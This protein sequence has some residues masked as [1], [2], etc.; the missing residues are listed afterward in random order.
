MR[1]NPLSSFTCSNEIGASASSS[2]MAAYTNVPKGFHPFLIYYTAIEAATEYKITANAS[3][4][5]PSI[6]TPMSCQAHLISPA[7]VHQL[8][9]YPWGV[10]VETGPLKDLQDCSIDTW[11]SKRIIISN[12]N[13]FQGVGIHA[14]AH[15]RTH[16]TTST[17][18]NSLQV[19]ALTWKF[20]HEVDVHRMRQRCCCHDEPHVLRRPCPKSDHLT[21]ANRQNTFI[22]ELR[23]LEQWR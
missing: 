22:A 10:A 3:H 13:R 12:N 9:C 23:H 8:F 4:A 5:T 16:I 7:A 11:R 20:L 18:S 21:W 14:G 1:R 6:S 15:T 17:T 19:W 2:K